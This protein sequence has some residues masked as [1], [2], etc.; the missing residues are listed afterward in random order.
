[1]A[2][3]IIGPILFSLCFF[4]IGFGIFFLGKKSYKEPCSS[5]PNLKGHDPI[6]QICPSDD[7][8]GSMTMATK[9]IVS[10][11]EHKTTH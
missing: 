10:H 9:S 5:I 2:E 4:G 8:N 7:D 6:C 1:M 3:F 11:P